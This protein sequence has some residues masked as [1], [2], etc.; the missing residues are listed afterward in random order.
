MIELQL[1]VESK[2]TAR[3]AQLTGSIVF[4]FNLSD[5]RAVL[6]FSIEKGVFG[7]ETCR[8]EVP[9]ELFKRFLDSILDFEGVLGAETLGEGVFLARETT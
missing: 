7:A 5:G 9:S 4:G 6:V 1:S 2:E 3:K 8:F